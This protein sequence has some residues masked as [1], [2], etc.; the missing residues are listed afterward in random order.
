MFSS[1]LSRTTHACQPLQA[2]SPHSGSEQT[3]AQD[4]P[5]P[6]FYP[7][8]DPRLQT[9]FI[10]TMRLHILLQKPGQ[11][12]NHL[13]D[14]PTW[15]PSISYLKLTTGKTN[16]TLSY[17]M[18]PSCHHLYL[19]G[20]YAVANYTQRAVL[21]HSAASLKGSPL[22]S[23]DG[24]VLLMTRLYHRACGRACSLRRDHHQQQS[25]DGIQ[26]EGR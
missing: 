5:A 23:T 14:G 11:R 22:G 9:Q 17:A 24:A 25:R 3:R 16:P 21:S 10:C 20:K 19:S 7:F 8:C 12:P 1:R 26:T 13:P 2:S 15:S 18:G 4:T 6:V